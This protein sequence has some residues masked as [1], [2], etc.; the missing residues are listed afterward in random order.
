MNRRGGG[1]CATVSLCHCLGASA[2]P[3][4]RAAM[5]EYHR[6]GSFNSENELPHDLGSCRSEIEVWAGLFFFPGGLS[7]GL[8][9]GSLLPE[10]S[11]DLPSVCVCALTSPFSKGA[12]HIRRGPIPM[13]SL[14]L[15][16]LF[17]DP[18]S[19]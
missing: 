5:T 2:Y 6:L 7:P 4:A 9:G 3:C 17:T 13:T 15:N 1:A 10:S 19:R 11:R 16:Y 12:S 8:A 14:C 18:A